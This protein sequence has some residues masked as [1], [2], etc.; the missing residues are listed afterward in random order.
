MSSTKQ[1]DFE[2]AGTSQS[3]ITRTFSAD[4]SDAFA[5]DKKLDGLV[6]SV[7]QKKQAVSSQSQ[8]LEAI[9]AKL[10][11]TEERLKEKQASPTKQRRNPTGNEPHR[12]PGNAS[13]SDGNPIAS[14]TP[15]IND[16][17]Q[18]TSGPAPSASTMSHWKPP[19]PGAL[20][21]TP[22]DSQQNSYMAN[23]PD[24]S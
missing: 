24:N 14:N 4:L 2:A 11:E 6:Q 17:T 12:L 22:G 5:M 18:R 13:Q 21:E 3:S 19:M 15:F 8:E 9:E 1:R 7:E 16:S 10:K 20:P 23:R